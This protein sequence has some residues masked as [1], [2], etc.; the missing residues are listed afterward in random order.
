MRDL[1][2]IIGFDITL[3]LFLGPRFLGILISQF[4]VSVTHVGIAAS[5]VQ[6]SDEKRL[7]CSDTSVFRLSMIFGA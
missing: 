6:D 5:Q 3:N 2:S 4:T 1:I 7:D